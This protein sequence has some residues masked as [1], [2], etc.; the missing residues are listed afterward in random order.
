MDNIQLL[1]NSLYTLAG[2]CVKKFGDIELAYSGTNSAAVNLIFYLG[3]A[4]N[5]GELEK[6]MQYTNDLETQM[7]FVTKQSRVQ[8]VENTLSKYN[9]KPA[10]YATCIELEHKNYIA[11]EDSNPFGYVVK[12]VKDSSVLRDWCLICDE[13]F[14]MGMGDSLKTFESVAPY[15]FQQNSPYQMYILYD[16]D[17]R[18]IT[19]SLLYLPEDKSMKAGH[20]FWGTKSE[21]RSNGAMTFLVDKM[22]KTANKK[23]FKSSVAQCYDTSLGIAKKLGFK[24]DGDVFVLFSNMP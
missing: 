19:V 20:Y 10:G 9:F 3:V 7:L 21:N 8:E 14:A 22:I 24:E 16:K 13:V 12:R 18:P 17:Q 1:F 4:K 23:G 15:L 5:P 2:H 6:C 11:R